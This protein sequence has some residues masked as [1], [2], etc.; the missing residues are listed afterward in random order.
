MPDPTGPG[1]KLLRGTADSRNTLEPASV[2]PG[3]AL[4]LGLFPDSEEPAE[5]QVPLR[6][7]G[8]VPKS[9]LGVVNRL[10]V[11][12]STFRVRLCLQGDLV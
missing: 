9:Q 4:R 11:A 10:R 8:L 12:A 7:L 6:A 2:C 1:V 5:V 3:A